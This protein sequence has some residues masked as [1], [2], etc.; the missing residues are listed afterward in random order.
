MLAVTEIPPPGPV[1]RGHDTVLCDGGVNALTR[2]SSPA[3]FNQVSVMKNKSNLKSQIRSS[4]IFSFL[5]TELTFNKPML[6]FFETES[7]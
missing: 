4:I 3:G 7:S 1:R 5:P 6:R 2:T